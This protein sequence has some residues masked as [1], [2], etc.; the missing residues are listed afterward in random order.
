MYSGSFTALITPFSADGSVDERAFQ[1]FVVWQ[2]NEGTNGL[3]PAG[4]TGETPVLS[5]DEYKR[6]L[7][8]CVEAA[9]GRAVIMA[10]S[11]TNCTAESIE[12][13]QYA[14]QVGANAVMVVTPYYNK[15]TQEG[16]YQ[17]YKAIHDSCNLPVFIYNIPGRSVVDISLDTMKR[18]AELPRIAGIKD[19]TADLSRPSQLRLALG[20]SFC[21]FSGDDHTSV[22][23][24]AQGGHGCISVTS[25][26]APRLCADLHRAWEEGSME[27]VSTLRDRLVPL[28]NALFCET[29]PAPVKY[30]ASLM[31][32]CLDRVRLPLVPASQNARERVRAA[33]TD[34]G[35]LEAV[36]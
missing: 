20:D 31:G 24:L 19:A 6:L 16:L 11:G 33:M 36:S 29:N 35:L 4:T 18:L 27:K 23:F 2:I 21:Q 26:I 34:A 17:H 22:A 5:P 9:S 10:G 1:D 32:H 7:R 13:T 28:H 12:R 14:E 8:L 15:P 3:V 30:A 25:N